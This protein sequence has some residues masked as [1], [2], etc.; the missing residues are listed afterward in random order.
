MLSR[1]GRFFVTDWTLKL[2]AIALAILSFYAIRNATSFEVNYDVPLKVSAEKGIAILDQPKTVRVA[3]RGSQEELRHLNQKGI[4][5]L[6]YPK[7]TD[8][9]GSE[10]VQIGFDDIEG[11][12]SGARPVKIEPGS[13]TLT[14]DREIEKTLQVA[15]PKTIGAPLLGKVELSY[16]PKT[17]QVRGSQRRLAD[18][19]A[20]D[21]EP[22]DVD[23]RVESFA[24]KVRVLSDTW[25]SEVTPE[26]ITVEVKIVTDSV[27][28]QWTNV[29]VKAMSEPGALKR[30]S[31]D[32]ASV[33]V[34][35]S[36][37]PE[38]METIT[39]MVVNV[40]ADCT[41]LRE[42]TPTQVPV[43]VYFPDAHDV[44]ARVE[45]NT[46]TATVKD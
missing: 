35:L 6:I 31:F 23:G 11:V 45:P 41:G 33:N 16:E 22:I 36:G 29:A 4:K 2:M 38:A 14:F 37:R 18:K 24:K 19:T 8:P 1:I 13:V 25:A 15:K 7:A 28:V 10:T 39:G 27:T 3:F 34:I 46:V 42:S 12:T 5:A 43:A 30:V 44:T 32:P 9:T 21:T 40:F 17:V 26:E 20:V